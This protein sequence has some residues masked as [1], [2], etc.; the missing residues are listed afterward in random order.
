MHGVVMRNAK[1]GNVFF[2][3]QPSHSP[4][5][6]IGMTKMPEESQKD[7]KKYKLPAGA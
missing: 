4:D 6:Q 1:L 5:A 2:L 7:K 3:D